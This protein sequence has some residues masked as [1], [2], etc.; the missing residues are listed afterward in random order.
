MATIS[1]GNPYTHSESERTSKAGHGQECDWCGQK[2]EVLYRY[3]RGR[4]W[5]C[6]LSCWKCYNY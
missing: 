2:P 3:N 4:G 1:K 6:N 5:F